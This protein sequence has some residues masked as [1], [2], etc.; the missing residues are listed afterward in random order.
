VDPSQTEAVYRRLA[1]H[2]DNLPG[3][4]PSTE[5]G[6]EQRILRRLFSPEE[7]ALAVRLA[8]IPEPAR[9]IAR[10]A[11]LGVDE[12]A[13]RLEEMAHKG[14][15]FSVRTPH[16]TLYQASYY[17]IGIWEFHVNDLDPEL[18]QDMEEYIPSLLRTEVWRRAPQLRTIPVAESIPVDRPVLP[19]EDA[20]NILRSN[21]RLA[22]APCICRREARMMGHGCDRPEETCLIMSWA[23]DY[24]VRNGIGRA[25]TLEEGLRILETAQD[26]GLVLQPGASQRPDNICCC[27]GCCCQVLKGFKRH[28]RPASMVSSP[29]V[30]SL[31]VEECLGCGDCVERCQME[32]LSLDDGH[33]VHDLDRCIG[34]GLCVTSCPAECLHLVRKPESAQAKVP[35]DLKQAALRLAWTRGKGVP[36][37]L[38]IARAE[39]DR[40]LARG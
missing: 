17:V 8:P 33:V 36:L 6:V 24:Y 35:R 29:F 3:G 7:A 16:R 19:Y 1:R 40:R 2:L 39:V 4:F 5:T 30:V 32:A 18:I 27:C 34:C 23:A 31:A 14:L 21:R 11:G 25:I 38:Q 28:P 26:T 13:A 15:I 10:R 9:I 20:A 22:V 37:L 12:A